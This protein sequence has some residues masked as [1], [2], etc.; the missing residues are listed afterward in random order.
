MAQTPRRYYIFLIMFVLLA[1]TAFAQTGADTADDDEDIG[2]LAQPEI[3]PDLKAGI[4][5]G[6]GY[7]MLVGAETNT[8]RPYFSLIGGA[9]LKYKFKKHWFIQ[10][11]TMVSRRGSNF[12][13]SVDE[14]ARIQL[15]YIDVP[16]LF[17]RGINKD[18]STIVFSGI[19][20]SRLINSAI[21]RENSVVPEGITPRVNKN[22]FLVAAGTQF[23][24]PFVG[25]Q[26]MFKYGLL[27]VNEG[28]V[29][30]LPPANKG[31]NLNNLI[32]EFNLLF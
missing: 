12:K 29:P 21:F 22:D 30:S 32:F 11:E 9:Y 27:N 24:T 6:C 7:S 3:N 16:L 26:L 31:L 20:Y 25:F 17:G 14:Y 28:L 8:S 10:P 15:Y 5:L 4:K 18:N 13:N 19:Q 2:T 1:H 23:H